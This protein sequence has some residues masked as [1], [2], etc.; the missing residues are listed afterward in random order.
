MVHVTFCQSFIAYPNILQYVARS[1]Q[2]CSL[3]AFGKEVSMF[4]KLQVL[5][6]P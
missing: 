1:N 4:F 2:I 6:P 3:N 5:S